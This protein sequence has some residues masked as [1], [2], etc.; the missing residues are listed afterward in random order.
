MIVAALLAFEAGVQ[1]FQLGDLLRESDALRYLDRATDGPGTDPN[2]VVVDR[3]VPRPWTADDAGQRR[4]SLLRPGSLMGGISIQGSKITT[5]N[6]NAWRPT[7][8]RRV[9]VGSGNTRLSP[10]AACSPGRRLRAEA[11]G[12]ALL[13][14]ARAAPA[15]SRRYRQRAGAGV[16]PDHRWLES[17]SHCTRAGYLPA[18]GA[19]GPLPPV[20]L[21]VPT[22]PDTAKAKQSDRHPQ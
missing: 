1:Y 8:S 12:W 21:C 13:R 20:P 6:P 14:R 15:V 2:V 3:G 7:F 10:S 16:R 22:R 18:R 11:P 19:S 5:Y 9:S 4:R 17:C